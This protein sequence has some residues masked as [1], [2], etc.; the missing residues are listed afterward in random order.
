MHST[1]VMDLHEKYTKTQRQDNTHESSSVCFHF[2]PSLSECP[3]TCRPPSLPRVDRNSWRPVIE[4]HHVARYHSTGHDLTSRAVTRLRRTRIRLKHGRTRS[5]QLRPPDV[6]R[7]VVERY[8][9]R[10][11]QHVRHS[12]V[13]VRHCRLTLASPRHTHKFAHTKTKTKTRYRNFTLQILSMTNISTYFRT[14]QIFILTIFVTIYTSFDRHTSHT[15]TYQ[16]SR[17]PSIQSG[18]QYSV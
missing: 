5:L 15:F 1:M 16:N 3:T 2:R 12:R 14:F 18:R 6:K 10:P 7:A 13:K 4:L 11:H 8:T 9:A 17:F